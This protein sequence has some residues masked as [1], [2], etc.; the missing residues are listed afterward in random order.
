MPWDDSGRGFMRRGSRGRGIGAVVG[1]VGIS[2]GVC[3][4]D[5]RSS[6]VV[7]HGRWMRAG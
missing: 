1:S 2:G 7:G 4:G 6:G 3:D 5:G